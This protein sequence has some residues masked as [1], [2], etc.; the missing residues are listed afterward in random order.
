MHAK[1]SPE[2]GKISQVSFKQTNPNF[3]ESA[4]ESNAKED[5]DYT[6]DKRDFGMPQNTSMIHSDQFL[7]E[8]NHED[9]QPQPNETCN[10]FELKDLNSVHVSEPLHFQQLEHSQSCSGSNDN[11]NPASMYS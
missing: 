5:T 7:I 6:A 9:G 8:T 4:N 2:H 11:P 3:F 1:D 10:Q